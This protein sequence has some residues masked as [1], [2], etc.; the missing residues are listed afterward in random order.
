MGRLLWRQT[1]FSHLPVQLT[2]KCYYSWL[3]FSCFLLIEH[4]NDLH[5]IV[6]SRQGS[7]WI[8]MT[9]KAFLRFSRKHC[10]SIG[11]T[12]GN[13]TLMEVYKRISGEVS[14]AK[15][16]RHWMEKPCYALVSFP[17]WGT[18]YEITWQFELLLF[19]MCLTDLFCRKSARRRIPVWQE[20]QDI[21]NMLPAAL[22]LL[23]PVV[24]YHCTCIH[25]WFIMWQQYAW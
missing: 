25:T 24:L 19:R 20:R 10:S 9:S 6:V 1:P 23:V 8:V 12:W 13:H 17:G 11:V 22:L 5:Y 16:R 21:A 3:L 18:V 2:C 14:C 7:I 4:I 15:F